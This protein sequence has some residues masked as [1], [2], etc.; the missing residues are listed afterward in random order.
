M[1]GRVVG[2]RSCLFFVAAQ[3]GSMMWQHNKNLRLSAGSCPEAAIQKYV[4]CTK[5]R[6][7]RSVT[8][9]K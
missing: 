5:A 6:P 8:D 2:G 7:L 1:V 4:S 3:C 9:L